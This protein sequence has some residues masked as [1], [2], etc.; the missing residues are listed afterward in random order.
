MPSSPACLQRA[1]ASPKSRTTRSMSWLSI[2]FGNER[3]RVSRIGEGAIGGSQS[4]EYVSLRPAQM[5]DLAHECALVF[6]DAFG[7]RGEMRDATVV[8]DPQLLE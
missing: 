7:K 3:C 4:S 5:G 6:V 1:A 8:T 2:S